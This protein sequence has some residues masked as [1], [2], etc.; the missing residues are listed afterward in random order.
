MARSKAYLFRGVE[1]R[2]RCDP[3]LLGDKDETPAEDTFRFPGGLEDFLV[4]TLGDAGLIGERP[5]SGRVEF[6]E[7]FGA[8]TVGSVEWAVAWTPARDGATSSYCNTMPTPEGGTHEAGFWAAITK[9]VRAHGERVGAR[10]AAQIAREDVE[11]AASA[12]DLGLHPRPGV[13][14]PDQGPAGDAGGGAAGRGRGARP[15]GHM[16]GRR[17]EDRPARSWTC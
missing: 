17:P 2:W 13:R 9:G 10:K 6:A 15:A 16:A 14:R 11:G 12:D 4:H 8:G 5:F 1:I 3:A 7:R